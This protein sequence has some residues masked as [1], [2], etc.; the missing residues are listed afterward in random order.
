MRAPDAVRLF[1]NAQVSKHNTEVTLP[2]AKKVLLR[3]ATDVYL[4]Y[5]S[6]EERDR[7]V[8]KVEKLGQ[9]DT[10]NL[11]R[12]MALAANKPYVFTCNIDVKDGLVNGAAGTFTAVHWK[13]GT[14]MKIVDPWLQFEAS[15][16]ERLLN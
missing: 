13:L 9:A 14:R 16:Q 7:A 3:R 10:V 11:P 6:D 12:K 8:A 5:R 1:S 2:D 4:G 15:E